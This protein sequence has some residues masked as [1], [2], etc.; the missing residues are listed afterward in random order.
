ML[1]K[2]WIHMKNKLWDYP[3]SQHTKQPFFLNQQ[4][5]KG[6]KTLLIHNC[7]SISE[8]YGNWWI[9]LSRQR[10]HWK[11]QAFS[12]HIRGVNMLDWLTEVLSK[13]IFFSSCLIFIHAS[14]LPIV[15]LPELIF[16]VLA[17]NAT[18]SLL[19][20]AKGYK[21]MISLKN[22]MH[23]RVLMN[24]KLSIKIKNFLRGLLLYHLYWKHF[25]C[26]LVAAPIVKT[27]N[28]RKFVHP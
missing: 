5:D 20:N 26:K 16:L 17:I 15:P 13:N 25:L 22:I 27:C 4:D 14:L 7:W 3:V 21:L 8:G 19:L 23:I 9:V 1:M 12:F 28:M 6:K 10:W 24:N 11:S 2:D 18:R